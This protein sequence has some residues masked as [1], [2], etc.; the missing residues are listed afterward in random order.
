MDRFLLYH[1][2]FSEP[3]WAREA[4]RL[5]RAILELDIKPSKVVL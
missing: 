5:E 2:V 1:H 4:Q 3:H